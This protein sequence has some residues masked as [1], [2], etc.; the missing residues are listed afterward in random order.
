MLGY[1]PRVSV[2]RVRRVRKD[3]NDFPRIPLLFSIPIIKADA[4]IIFTC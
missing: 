3:V 4:F 2:G 1:V